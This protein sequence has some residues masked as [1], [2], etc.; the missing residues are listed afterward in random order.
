[1]RH[2]NF[3]K[4]L[5]AKKNQE[6]EDAMLT[7][8]MKELKAKTF[9]EQA[10]AQREKIKTLKVTEEAPAEP[11]AEAEKPSKLSEAA[12]K[13]ANASQ[14][15]ASS[16]KAPSQKSKSQKPAWAMT[17]KQIEDNKEAEIDE[18]LEF[19]YELDYEKYMEDFEVRQ[20]LAVIKERVDAIKKEPDWKQKMA[21]EWNETGAVAAEAQ[22]VEARSQASFKSGATNASK[23]SYQKRMAEAKSKAEER[24]EWDGSVTSE[25]RQARAEDR[26]A[27]KIAQEVLK[28]NAKLRGIHSKESIKK[29]LEKEALRQMKMV[30][31]GEYPEPVVARLTE[32]GTVDRSDPSN[33]PYLHK[34][35]AV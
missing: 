22:P 10:A 1:M 25:K 5:E 18:L 20:A 6:R 11:Q 23:Q 8:Q 35:P 34:N 26:M 24:P 28:D 14:K 30:Q 3:L 16:V 17:E 15:A 31:G 21:D 7:E 19:A 2:R 4:D 33:L 27:S 29:I 9:K 12:L 32:K 13:A